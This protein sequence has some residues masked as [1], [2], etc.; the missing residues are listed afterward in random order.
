MHKYVKGAVIGHGTYGQVRKATEKATGRVGAPR[1]PARPMWLLQ[2]WRKSH[3]ATP[4]AWAW[5]HAVEAG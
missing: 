4:L 5:H 3:V 2:E 1:R